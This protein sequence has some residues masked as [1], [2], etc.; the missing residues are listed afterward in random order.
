[1]LEEGSFEELVDECYICMGPCKTKS[2]CKCATVV[3]PSCLEEFRMKSGHNE[4]TICLDKYPQT[5]SY[6]AHITTL[7][8]YLILYLVSGVLGQLLLALVQQEEVGLKPPW[9][10]KFTIVALCI[11]S[12]GGVVRYIVKKYRV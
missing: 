5:V 3:H 2:P 7:F 10:V 11:C 6:S 8:F 12:I 9:S 4:C 1:M